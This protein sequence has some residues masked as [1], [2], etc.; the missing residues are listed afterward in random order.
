[1]GR[2]HGNSELDILATKAIM[3]YWEDFAEKV[4]AVQEKFNGSH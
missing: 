2:L 3:T 4:E 1:M